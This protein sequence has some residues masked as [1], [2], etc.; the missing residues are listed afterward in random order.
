MEAAIDNFMNS[1]S[2]Y[3]QCI[4][5]ARTT[6]SQLINAP[7]NDTVLVDN[8]SEA[9]NSILRNFEPALSSDEFILDLSTAYG[10]FQGLYNWMGART[11]VQVY[12]AP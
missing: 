4:L 6:L 11:G 5:D 12:Y 2:G 7:L 1:A 9:I 10:P 3:R 8:A